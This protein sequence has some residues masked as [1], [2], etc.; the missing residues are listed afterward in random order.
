MVAVGET[1]KLAEWYRYGQEHPATATVALPSVVVAQFVTSL[2]LSVNAV[3]DAGASDTAKLKVMVV[4]A[5]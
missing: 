1:Q 3:P 2:S 4:A 5:L